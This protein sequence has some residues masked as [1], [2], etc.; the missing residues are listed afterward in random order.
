MGRLY[1]F[2]MHNSPDHY[3]IQKVTHCQT[4]ATSDQP[5]NNYIAGSVVMIHHTYI[6]IKTF[7]L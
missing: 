1:Y 2:S 7:S 6:V 5:V 4:M 3:I